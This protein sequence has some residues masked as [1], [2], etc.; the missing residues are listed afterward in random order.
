MF[1]TIVCGEAQPRLTSG[2]E[3][4]LEGARFRLGS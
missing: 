4:G 3:A 2:G 1:K